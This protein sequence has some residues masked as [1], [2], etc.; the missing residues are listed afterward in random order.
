[1]SLLGQGIAKAASFLGLRDAEYTSAQTA[2]EHN[3][4]AGVDQKT[5]TGAP[6]TSMSKKTQKRRAQR[7]KQ[8]DRKNSAR[9]K[10]QAEPNHPT[11]PPASG[12]C[13]PFTEPK[14]E[15]NLS[16]PLGTPE[17]LALL[18]RM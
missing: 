7:Q 15:R 5:N 10:H 18:E 8:K 4:E 6:S 16:L 2:V 11:R 9:N 14:D 3:A 12:T 17:D 13:Q 1:M